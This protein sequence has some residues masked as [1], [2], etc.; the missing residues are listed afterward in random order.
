M[1][2]AVIVI[3][4]AMLVGWDSDPWK[5]WPMFDGLG[6]PMN[7]LYEWDEFPWAGF[8][9]RSGG[10]SFICVRWHSSGDERCYFDDGAGPW[11]DNLE[12]IMPQVWGMKP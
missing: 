6:Q 8:D 4:I 5:S 11:R 12:D 9:L 10:R 1:R 3:T 7:Q 2:L